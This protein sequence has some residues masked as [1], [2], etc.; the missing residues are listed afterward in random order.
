MIVPHGE[1]TNRLP[2]AERLRTDREFREVVRKGER[3]STL[4]FNIY[5]DHL[6]GD[7]GKVGISVGK[8]AG[9]AAA[10]N[11]VKRVLRE[12]YRLHKCVFPG[13][14]RTAITVKKAPLLPGLASVT[15]ELL[16]AIRRRWGPKEGQCDQASSSSA[17]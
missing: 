7:V 6:G 5:R 11:R 4:H 14:S 2:A 8:R 9:R 12:F 1:R 10:R 16:P 17:H 15:E 13:G 3:A